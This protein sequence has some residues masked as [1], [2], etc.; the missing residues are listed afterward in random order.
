MSRMRTG[1]ASR[2]RR[3]G[4]QGVEQ[5]LEGADRER[6]HVRFALVET[7]EQ[8][9]CGLARAGH[10]HPAVTRGVAVRVGRS[11]RSRLADLGDYGVTGPLLDDLE[12]RIETYRTELAAPRMAIVT[13]K[14]ATSGLKAGIA[15]ASDLLRTQLDKLMPILAADHPAFGTDYR[16]ARVIVDSGGG[17]ARKGRK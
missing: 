6:R 7:G 10:R 17:K 2:S 16:N 5:Q 3:S 13:R 8:V 9:S 4:G 11:G 1:S 12:A 14:G 15:A